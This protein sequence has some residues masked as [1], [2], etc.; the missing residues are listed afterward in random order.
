MHSMAS[1][2]TEAVS[3]C[4]LA[5]KKKLIWKSLY[6]IKPFLKSEESIDYKNF[7]IIF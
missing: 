5:R 1:E 7:D 2:S 3:V 4:K 6:R